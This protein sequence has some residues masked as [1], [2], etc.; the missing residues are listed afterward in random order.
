M[1]T[2]INLLNLISSLPC[3][4]V[5]TIVRC[6]NTAMHRA[7]FRLIGEHFSIALKTMF[8]NGHMLPNGRCHVYID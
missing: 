7:G 3:Y 8:P 2:L 6:L 1:F 5:R 4:E